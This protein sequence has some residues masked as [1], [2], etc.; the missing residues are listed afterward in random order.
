MLAT[1]SST[2]FDLGRDK[3]S[4]VGIL[5]MQRSVGP[6]N[7]GLIPNSGNSLFLLQGVHT[8]SGTQ[9]ASY[10]RGTGG[11]LPAGKAAGASR[12]PHISI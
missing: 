10:S 9:P 6:R 5:I 3:N 4:S 11:C 8:V 2:H 7:R 1:L 12:L